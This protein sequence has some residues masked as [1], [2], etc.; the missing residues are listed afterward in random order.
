MK[1]RSSDSAARPAVASA[2]HATASVLESLTTRRVFLKYGAGTA[3]AFGL[4]GVGAWRARADVSAAS[5]LRDR[6]DPCFKDS[7]VGP[8]FT[9]PLRIPPALAPVD[10][11]AGVDVFR[12][13]ERKGVAQIV[14]GVQ[15][16]IWGY[17]GMTPGPTILARR[18]S[19]PRRGRR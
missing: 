15:T 10:Q 16:P 17:N 8:P 12:L 5:L 3:A 18:G 7:P 6:V 13:S 2:S 11:Q 14:P 19:R 9:Q 1:D 4:A